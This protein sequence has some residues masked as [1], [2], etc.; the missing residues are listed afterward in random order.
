MKDQKLAIELITPPGD[1]IRET[2]EIKGISLN[3]LAKRLQLDDRE[4]TALL[5]GE[6]A[7]DPVLASRLATALNIPASFWRN[8]EADYRKDMDQ[9]AT[10]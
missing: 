9:N 7:L 3:Y 8:R 2:M 4:M 5:R 6:I 10:N 1:T